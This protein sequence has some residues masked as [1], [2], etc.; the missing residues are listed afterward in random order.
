MQALC[1]IITSQQLTDAIFAITVDA[2]E[3]GRKALPGQ[4]VHVKC[5]G[6]TLLRRPISICDAKEGYLKIV[7]QAKGAGTKWL[8]EKKSGALDLLG[9]LG[10]GFDVSGRN[11]LLVGGGIGVPPLLFAARRAQGIST[12]ILGFQNADAVILKNHF[13]DV[14]KETIITTND[15]SAGEEGFVTGPLARLLE[16]GGYDGVL[17]CGPTPMLKAVA[18]VAAQFNVPCQVSL[19]ERMACGVGACVGCAVMMNSGHNLRVCHDGPV[20]LASEVAW[21]G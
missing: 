2:G 19:E 21:N 8:A 3:L 14:C 13:R 7:F 17:S 10:Y 4:F 15:G 9:P 1:P 16:K 6:Q 5:G 11:I 18:Q 20:F 12:A